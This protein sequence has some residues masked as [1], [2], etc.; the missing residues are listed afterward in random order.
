MIAEAVTRLTEKLVLP[1]LQIREG[2]VVLPLCIGMTLAEAQEEITR[3]NLGLDRTDRCGKRG[4][5]QKK[6]TDNCD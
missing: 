1:D 3:R 6:R 2:T 5:D 4:D